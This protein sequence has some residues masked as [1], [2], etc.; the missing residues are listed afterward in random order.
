LDFGIET[1][2]F[3]GLNAYWKT[4][5]Q[6]LFPFY[7][8]AIAGVIIVACRYSSRLTNL[9]GS[10]A[11]PLLA[12]LFLLSYMKLLRTVIDATSVAVIAQYPQNTSYAV[13][14][15][16][17]NLC[18]CQ[19]PHVYLFI[20]AVAT[21]VFL[22]L[23]YTLVLLFIQPLR[24]VSHLRPLKWINK[25]APVYDAYFSP[26]KDKHR[27]WFGLI[28]FVRGIF[29]ILLTVTS[30]ANPEL[31]VFILFL[32]VIFLLFF[33]SV[34]YV[35]KRM[36]VRLLES[37]ALLNLTILSAGTLYKW[38]STESRST[39]LT[40][41]VGIALAHFC[42]IVV[43]SLI[44]PCLSSGWRCTRQNQSYDVIDEHIC[45][46]ITHE[47]IED[48][49]LESLINYAPRPVTAAES[50]KYTATVTKT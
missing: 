27:Y 18:Y 29:L 7:I 25:L 6:F 23:P 11:V 16:D 26:L 15:L 4:W 38:E 21:L 12:T 31:N 19:H 8:W 37:A 20:A 9:I 44:K 48:P 1:C 40:V 34:K 45:E 42:I 28:L 36:T 43:L 13:W 30:V 46:D 10:R 33:M 17:G 24:R 47:R 35:Y 49:E 41:S 5:L 3:V 50:I 14:Y 2:F 22:W 32:F 39:L